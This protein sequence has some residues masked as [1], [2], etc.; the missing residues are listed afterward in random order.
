MKKITSTLILSIFLMTVL[1]QTKEDDFK[2]ACD[3]IL[4]SISKKN[5]AGLNAY[6][7]PALGVYVMHRTGAM[8]EWTNV[9]KLDGQL[10]YSFETFTIDKKDLKKYTLKFSAIPAYDCGESIWKK[11]GY[12]ADSTKKYKPVSEIIAFRKKYEHETVSKNVLNQV[13]MVENNSRKIVFTG[14]KGDG[15]IFYLSYINGKWW[16]SI[17]DAV[18]T[19][20]SA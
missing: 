8:D 1:G 17:L 7:S 11:R 6:V 15:V 4:Q 19:D 13:K 9:K 5:A 16:L 10:P 18:T 2:K 20:C 3:D 12:F 14:S